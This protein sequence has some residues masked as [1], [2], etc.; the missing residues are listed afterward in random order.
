M[1]PSHHMH[2]KPGTYEGSGPFESNVS[3][4]EDCAELCGWDMRTKMLMLASS[5]R[6]TARTYY[7]SLPEQ[8]RRDNRILSSRLNNRFGNAGKHHYMWLKKNEKRRR[9]KDE[10]ISSLAHAI[11]QLAPKAYSEL[12]HRSQEQ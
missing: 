3:H 5:L 11:R 10:S 7:M 9:V 12:D 8:E 6:G 2:V 4:F 1:S